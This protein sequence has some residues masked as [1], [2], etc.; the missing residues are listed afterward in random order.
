VSA[1]SDATTPATHHSPFAYVPQRHARVICLYAYHHVL[2]ALSWRGFM[3]TLVFQ[4]FITPLLGLAVWTA[5][6]PG[7]ARVSTYFVALMLVQLLTVCYEG[8]TFA[9]ELT[10]GGLARMMLHPHP[11]VLQVAGANLAWRTW[12]LLIGTPAVAAI[13]VLA[14][15]TFAPG[16]VLLALPALLMAGVLRFLF[17]YTVVLTGLWTQQSGSIL[18]VANTLIFLLGGI[19]APVTLF[20]DRYRALGEALPF[21]SMAGFPTEI[22]TGSLSSGQIAA[23]YAWQVLWT[24]LFAAVAMVVWRAGVRKYTAVGA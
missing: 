16:A 15:V 22:A 18:G 3:L 4:Q 10:S 12:H 14:G 13:A 21:R 24:A 2:D 23:G 11:I 20:P 7:N 19:A 6:L 17:T 9:N 1:A 5:A 8:H